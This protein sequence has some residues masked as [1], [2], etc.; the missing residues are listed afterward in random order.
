M[1]RVDFALVLTV[2]LT[3]GGGIGLAPLRHS[4]TAG[5]ASS[6]KAAT[7]GGQ[8]A[9]PGA[10]TKGMPTS[11]GKSGIPATPS[12]PGGTGG[13]RQP[14]D[15]K[16]VRGFGGLRRSGVAAFGGPSYLIVEASPREA[17]V[18]L[19]GRLLGVAGELVARA[20]PLPPGRHALEIVAPGFG[21]YIAQFVVAPGSFPMRFRVTLRPG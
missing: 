3:L 19:D 20:F 11:S 10:A 1:K 13:V 5:I 8:A 12:R 15:I 2:L 21:P 7:G 4:A 18:F 16:V 14:C 9:A 6:G 17:Q